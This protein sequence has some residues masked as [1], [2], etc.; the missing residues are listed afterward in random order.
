M[1]YIR[2]YY[3]IVFTPRFREPVFTQDVEREV[4]H[5]LYR[6][7]MRFKGFVHRINGTADHIHLLVS[8]P[9]VKAI[10]DMIQESSRQIRNSRLIPQWK[11]WEE[12]YSSFT[13]SYRELE[14]IKNYIKNQKE[15]HRYKPFIEEYRDWLIENGVAESDPYFPKL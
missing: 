3:H 12:G 6:Q 14:M 15:H 4:Y 7:I 13:C 9:A 8:L 5:L 10:S 11:G 1:S 2:H